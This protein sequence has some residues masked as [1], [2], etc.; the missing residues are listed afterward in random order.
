MDPL[1]KLL[2]RL[3]TISKQVNQLK[4]L[5]QKSK[6]KITLNI[7]PVNDNEEFEL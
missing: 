1:S 2:K 3:E 7:L 5:G 6:K 4:N